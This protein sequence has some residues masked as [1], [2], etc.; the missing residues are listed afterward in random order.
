MRSSKYS[1]NDH[2]GR[3]D[4]QVSLRAGDLEA[5]EKRARENRPP[6]SAGDLLKCHL[7]QS[8]IG[9]IEA[10]NYSPRQLALTVGQEES[11]GEEV[12]PSREREQYAIGAHG[13][14]RIEAA[15]GRVNEDLLLLAEKIVESGSVLPAPLCRCRAETLVRAAGREIAARAQVFTRDARHVASE[16]RPGPGT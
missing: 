1:S 6:M 4:L 15:A 5:V 8:L 9:R 14:D 16:L 3:E 11:G 2:T 12:G 13:Q 7:Y 10:G